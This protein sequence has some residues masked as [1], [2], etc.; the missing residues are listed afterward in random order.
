MLL[1]KR[2]TYSRKRLECQ[3]KLFCHFFFCF[4]KQDIYA[5]GGRLYNKYLC[6]KFSYFICVKPSVVKAA[7]LFGENKKLN[8]V[9]FQI[10]VWRLV[11][12]LMQSFDIGKDLKMCFC[13]MICHG[14]LNAPFH[15]A[16]LHKFQRIYIL[17]WYDR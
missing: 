8:I 6:S 2:N 17:N 16:M 1:W 7:S 3:G 10:K 5:I 12:K 9:A 4:R 11:P 13:D 15:L 14:L